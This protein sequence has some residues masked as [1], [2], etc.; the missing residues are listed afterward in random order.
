[1]LETVPG[2]PEAAAATWERGEQ[3]SLPGPSAGRARLR[4]VLQGLAAAG[5]GAGVLWLWSPL[6][7]VVIGVGAVVTL[8]A[9]SSPLG[10]YAAIERGLAALGRR[11]GTALT[12][13]VMGA[14]F[15]LVF[16]PF[17]LL[18]RRGRRDP[19]RRFFEAGATTYWEPRT[20][21]RS[22]SASRTRP[23]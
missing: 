20:A 21:G 11:T 4:G 22:A 5:L 18:L 19:M 1:M 12:W 13:I 17:G 7:G 9:L 2:R 15:Y 3:T 23:Y 16:L 8:A 10:L 14:T 6:G